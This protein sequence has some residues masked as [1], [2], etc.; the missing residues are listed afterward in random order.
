MLI[1]LSKPKKVLFMFSCSKYMQV[2]YKA[3]FI[4]YVKL[5]G[6]GGWDWMSLGAFLL[7]VVSMIL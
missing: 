4:Y 5:W 1:D 6:G 2:G 7:N 3:S